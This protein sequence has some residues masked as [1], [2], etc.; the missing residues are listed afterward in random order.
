MTATVR[1]T[2]VDKTAMMLQA[3]RRAEQHISDLSDLHFK[4]FERKCLD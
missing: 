1:E 3:L 2:S 4:S